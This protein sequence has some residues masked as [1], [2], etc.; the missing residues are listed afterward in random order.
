LPAGAA[1]DTAYL[2]LVAAEYLLDQLNSI[3]L[4]YFS[5]SVAF[6]VGFVEDCSVDFVGILAV[7]DSQTSALTL[8]PSRKLAASCYHQMRP[9]AAS[10]RP[11]YFARHRGRLIDA[12]FVWWCFRT[13]LGHYYRRLLQ[14]VHQTNSKQCAKVVVSRKETP[15]ALTYA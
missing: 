6:L 12:C 11:V 5:I 8:S 4:A 1:D 3:Q 14:A 13:Y 10:N 9:P 15:R 2:H 7:V